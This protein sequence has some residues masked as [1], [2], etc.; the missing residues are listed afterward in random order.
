VEGCGGYAIFPHIGWERARFDDTKL[1]S[2]D[3]A[4]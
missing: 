4:F 3:R 1:M 2:A